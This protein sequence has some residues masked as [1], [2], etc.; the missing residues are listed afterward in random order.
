MLPCKLRVLRGSV[1]L[2]ALQLLLRG[3]QLQALRRRLRPQLRELRAAFEQRVALHAFPRQL[4]GQFLPLALL[5]HHASRRLRPTRL[6]TRPLELS[7]QLLDVG[8]PD[9]SGL[10]L[11]LELLDQALHALRQRAVGLVA[12]AVCDPQ[13]GVLDAGLLQLLRAARQR[14]DRLLLLLARVVG[15][16]MRLRERLGRSHPRALVR[17]ELRLEAHAQLAQP[18]GGYMAGRARRWRGGGGGGGARGG[19]DRV[20]GHG[21]R[22]RLAALL[23]RA[24]ALLRRRRGPLLRAP[25]RLLGEHRRPALRDGALGLLPDRRAVCRALVG[26]LLPQDVRVRLLPPGRDLR[27]EVVRVLVLHGLGAQGRAGHYA[28]EDGGGAPSTVRLTRPL[29]RRSAGTVT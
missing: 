29:W 24:D 21:A 5:D 25:R 26:R 17:G 1:L 13:L 18:L 23:R 11:P 19:G 15:A 2:G 20:R 14:R 6:V 27:P 3:L 28:D 7:L 4:L 8:A 10:R 12:L 22:R 16:A 9:R